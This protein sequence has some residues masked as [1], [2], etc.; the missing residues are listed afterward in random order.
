MFK[1]MNLQSTSSRRDTRTEFRRLYGEL[2]PQDP[3]LI[4]LLSS[5]IPDTLQEQ[6]SQKPEDGCTQE[7]IDSLPRV[8]IGTIK[9][10]ELCSICFENFHDDEYPLLVKLPHCGHKF[11]L[12]CIAVWLGTNR[13]CP[14]CRDN[15][16][17]QQDKLKGLDTSKV[18][19]E[20]DW[21]MY[22]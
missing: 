20:E 13:T 17:E 3:Q 15:V 12:Q 1:D 16:M 10:D 18:E 21:G 5:L 14:V 9:K 19:L 2:N 4:A 6:W 8:S 22:G 7:F 11:D